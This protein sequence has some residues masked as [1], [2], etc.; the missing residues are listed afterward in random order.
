MFSNT[1]NLGFTTPG[2]AKL[3]LVP[4]QLKLF[5]SNSDAL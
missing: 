4:V 1:I 5:S 2:A 3:L